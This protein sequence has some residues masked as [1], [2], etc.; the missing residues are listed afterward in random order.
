MALACLPKCILNRF[1]VLGNDL[2]AAR[3]SVHPDET[4]L[5]AAA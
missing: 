3:V 4:T 1:A 5:L 2:P